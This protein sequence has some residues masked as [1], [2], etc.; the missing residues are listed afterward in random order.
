MPHTL[1]AL[2]SQFNP[3]LPL[4][5]ASTAPASWYTSAEFFGAE[6]EL[7]KA[8][9][10]FVAPVAWFREQG[11]FHS[12][13]FLGEPYV[14]L[15]GDDGELR[16]FYN[17]CRHHA[18]CLV[19]GRGKTESLTCPYHGWNYSLKGELLK[20]PA[21]G[22]VKGFRKNEMGLVPIPLKV[23]GPFVLLNFSGKEKPIPEGWAAM[24][25]RFE[26]SGYQKLHF[27]VRREY[28]IKCNWKVYVDNYLDGGYHVS[29]LHQ[30][31]ASQLEIDGYK[32][33][34]FD[35]W[36]LQSCGGKGDARIGDEALYALAYPNF[37]INR[38]GKIMDTNWVV[39]LGHDRCLTVFDYYF[40]DPDDR[41]FVE[42]SLLP[43]ERVQQED[44]AI[45]ESVQRGLSSR[46]YG[47]GRYSVQHESGMHL[48]HQWLHRDLSGR[49]Q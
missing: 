49:A 46:A 3:A 39:P 22:A 18:T 28:E 43:S 38:Y 20:A 48:F 23:I 40:A 25:Q 32:I 27:V 45:S 30:G 13:I 41:K 4:A 44:I 10:Q 8:Q 7:L 21:L 24:F 11:S 42:E 17:V 29:Q 36:T 12:G 31:L 33:E 6:A 35:R 19:E 15:R 1:D 47:A 37:M 5:E 14:I 16:A 9:W 34:N 26:A 2:L